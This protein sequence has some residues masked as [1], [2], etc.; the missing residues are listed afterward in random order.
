MALGHLF[1]K[2]GY[3]NYN[4]NKIAHNTMSGIISNPKYKGYY[5]GNKVRVVD[6]FTKKQKFL[7]PE[8]WVMFKDETGGIVPAIVSEEVWDKANEVLVRRSE[9]VKARQ[10][11]CN[12]ANLLTGKLFCAHCGAAYYR[13]ESK[14]KDGTAQNIAHELKTPV[15]S[16]QGYLETIVNNPDLPREKLDLFLSRSY[17]QSNRLT[18]LLSDISLLTR[19]EEAPNMTEKETVNLYQMVQSIFNEVTLQLEE[20]QIKAQNLL[21]T[22]LEIQG[23]AS[24]LYSIFRNLTDNTIAY[25]GTDISIT[26]QCFRQGEKFYYFSFADTGI[27]VSPEHLGRL[28]E[29]FYR[30]DKGRSRKLGGTGLGLAIVK[31]AV[32]LHGGS[33]FAKKNPEGGLEF[34][35]TLS[36]E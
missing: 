16:I 17:A 10:G 35:F 22:D 1:Y 3:R 12:H 31:N 28:F 19:M 14:S 2:Q 9:D 11:V 26:I 36:K 34:I 13:R 24:L 23:N 18:H 5:V 27:G 29:R 15:S 4:G 20:K 21:P 25:A 30:V 32:L 8:E 33:I 7:P 6:M